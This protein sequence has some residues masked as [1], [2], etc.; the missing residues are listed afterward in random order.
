[1][2]NNKKAE[3]SLTIEAADLQPTM[4][5]LQQKF[6]SETHR[7]ATRVAVFGYFSKDK[8]TLLQLSLMSFDDIKTWQFVVTRLKKGSNN[9]NDF[10]TESDQAI[11]DPESIAVKKLL[12]KLP[13]VRSVCTVIMVDAM[14]GYDLV[15]ALDGVHISGEKRNTKFGVIKFNY[16][17]G[18]VVIPTEDKR[19]IILGQLTQDI[20]EKGNTFVPVDQEVDKLLSSKALNTNSINVYKLAR[21]KAIASWDYNVSAM[22]QKNKLEGIAQMRSQRS[23]HYRLINSID[24]LV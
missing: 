23:D 18:R 2:T 24:T 5:R 3:K 11:A 17:V 8:D 12:A 7:E 9:I 10:L 20:N 21:D 14:I 15:V 16:A 13:T 4:E 19:Y 1:M 6:S 22:R